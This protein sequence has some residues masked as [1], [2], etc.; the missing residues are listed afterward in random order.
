MG[1]I[2]L[3]RICTKPRPVTV[4]DQQRARERNVPCGDCSARIIRSFGGRTL[5]VTT[6]RVAV[7]VSLCTGALIAI[8]RHDLVRLALERGG[9][10]PDDAATVA[11]LVLIFAGSIVGLTLMTV[12]TRGL[13]AI[14]RYRLVAALS[15]L[16]LGLYVV[17]AIVLRGGYGREGLAGAF[18]I[19]A[20][21]G[22]AAA[23]ISLVHEL[24]VP[25]RRFGF[26]VILMPLLLASLFRRRRVRRSTL[27]LSNRFFASCFCGA[28]GDLCRSR[29]NRLGRRGAPAANR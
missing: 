12:A 27:T 18:L 25:L 22:G 7:I 23:A 19:S 5:V 2:A 8:C 3:P 10:T 20:L 13:F 14:G 28:F 1:T 26:D 9:L 11:A 17:R 15:A 24:D 29:P 16:S 4:D 21:A 6:F